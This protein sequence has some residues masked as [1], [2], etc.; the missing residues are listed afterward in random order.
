MPPAAAYHCEYRITTRGAESRAR[1]AAVA[2]DNLALLLL[3]MFPA[4]GGWM[5]SDALERDWR[6]IR[7]H[8]GIHCDTTPA[9]F[10]MADLVNAGHL[11]CR[12]RHV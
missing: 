7:R 5:Q 3:N 1:V 4:D 8:T 10:R 9:A 2:P 11:E 6:R 12:R